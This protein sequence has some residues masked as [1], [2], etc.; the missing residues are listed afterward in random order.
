MLYVTDHVKM[1]WPA[2]PQPLDSFRRLFE[3]YF[4]IFFFLSLDLPGSQTAG[5]VQ[6]C[7]RWC[8]PLAGRGTC[9]WWSRPTWETMAMATAATG[10]AAAAVTAD[11]DC[12]VRPRR[13]RSPRRWTDRRRQP[14]TGPPPVADD[15]PRGRRRRYSKGPA[16]PACWR[17]A[18]RP[19]AAWPV[20]RRSC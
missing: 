12:R 16:W 1:D 5:T 9:R 4:L 10:A 7:R 3:S 17:P 13:R 20:A 15:R 2:I 11:A 14:G 6:L 18:R 8:W 19:A